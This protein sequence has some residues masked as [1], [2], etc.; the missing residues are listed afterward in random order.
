[1]ADQQFVALER[2][3][4][5]LVKLCEQ[6]HRENH[7][8]QNKESTWLA[9]RANLVRKNEKAVQQLEAMVSRLHALEKNT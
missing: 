7:A 5:K 9:E 6:L 2:K 4:D 1:M 3:I 8:L